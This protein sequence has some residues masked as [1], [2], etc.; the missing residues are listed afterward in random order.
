MSDYP[1]GEGFVSVEGMRLQFVEAGP[2]NGPPVVFLHG[3]GGGIED[4]WANLGYFG[5]QGYHV[6]A[7]S[8]PGHGKSEYH[9]DEW[10]PAESGKT[11]IALLDA[12]GIDSAP[13]IAHSAGGIAAILAALEFP[14]RVES[15]VLA[16]P[17]GLTRKMGWPLRLV[18]IPFVGEAMWHPRLLAGH[19]AR[20]TIFADEN[21]V[22]HTIMDEWVARH[23]DP[24]QRKAFFD[25]LRRGMDI[26]GM[27]RPYN[28]RGRAR[29]VRCPTLIFWGREDMI[30][31]SP[32][33]RDGRLMTWPEAEFRELSPCA[34][35]PQVEQAEV[36]NREAAGF[37]A[38]AGVDSSLRSE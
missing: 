12:W 11:V 26:R 19:R 30:V 17:G 23:R 18:T 3:I 38:R 28:L 1:L 14:E 36:F 29:D 5:E 15:L 24:Q 16:A 31:P 4:W 37:L 2:S 32:E 10:D 20:K 27:K 22:N 8:M 35:W 7:P 34:H 13:L 21:L 33:T 9:P 25:L 6:L